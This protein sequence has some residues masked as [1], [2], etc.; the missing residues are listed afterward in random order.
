MTSLLKVCVCLNLISQFCSDHLMI[1]FNYS[2]RSSPP[3]SQQLPRGN[4]NHFV[5]DFP[6]ANMEGLCSYLETTDF[7]VCFQSC[8]VDTVCST[9]KLLILNA[10]ELFILK[11]RL[12]I[13]QYPKWFTSD[14]RHSI[15]CL[16]TLRRKYKKHPSP[17]N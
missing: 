9:L 5:F 17:A 2:H 4:S 13:H 11:G 16:R 12:K 3:N 10:M 7:S 1:T 14:I 6:K 8:D 15:N